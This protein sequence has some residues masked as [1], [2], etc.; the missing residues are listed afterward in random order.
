[1]N[2]KISPNKDTQT[3]GLL[4]I[5]D[6]HLS[7]RKP[8]RRTDVNFAGTVLNKLAQAFDIVREHGL[9]PV[10][11]GDLFDR[12]GE[13][14]LMVLSGLLHLLRDH[15]DAGGLIPVTLAGN[16]DMKDATLSGDTALSVIHESGL[17]RVL[18]D[19]VPFPVYRRADQ[20]GRG[21]KDSCIAVLVPYSYGQEDRLLEDG[22]HADAFAAALAL[23]PG[24][25]FSTVMAPDAPVIALTHADFAFAG[26]YP[27]AKE[28]VEVPGVDMVVNGHMHKLCPTVRRGKTLWWNPGNITRMSMD[29]ESHAPRVWSWKPGE[30]TLTGIHLRYEKFVFNRTGVAVGPDMNGLKEDLRAQDA[31]S[32]EPMS[33]RFVEMLKAQQAQ[34][35]PLT[36]D[37]SG[38]MTEIQAVC[39]EQKADAVVSDI[40]Q[41]MLGSLMIVDTRS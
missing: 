14:D 32:L 12:A 10:I 2:Q 17:L 3:N 22:V 40:L 5:G 34:E 15:S 33:S 16:H 36:E 1:M 21:G 38:L 11:L 9:Q 29:C 41:Q 23:A 26:A 8:G 7:S 28:I 18:E 30:D 20:R 6:P 31:A 37:A 19:A 4:F 35:A 25:P 13:Q 24:Q 27:G 39:E